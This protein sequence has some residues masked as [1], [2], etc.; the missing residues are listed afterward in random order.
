R[1]PDGVGRISH[2][3]RHQG[4]E[5]NLREVDL[6]H[7]VRDDLLELLVQS[8]ALL[9]VFFHC[10]LLEQ[11]VHTLVRVRLSIGPDDRADIRSQVSAVYA[12]Y[13]VTPIPDTV[14]GHFEIVTGNALG[15]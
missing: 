1:T 9:E 15:P 12:N 10:G 14:G 4:V 8:L 6:W 2:F 11:L 7:V 5:G 3:F 13:G